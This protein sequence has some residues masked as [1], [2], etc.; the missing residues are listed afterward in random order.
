MN[1]DLYDILFSMKSPG[2]W[3]DTFERSWQEVDRAG[4]DS[5]FAGTDRIVLV[6]CGTS[7]YAGVYGKELFEV[8]SGIP[9][10][11]VDGN[12]GRY[13]D[14]KMYTKSTLY[15]GI[16][17][18][19]NSGTAVESLQAASKNGA[20]TLCITGDKD[21]RIAKASDVV[22]FFP[23][24]V[25]RVAT[26]TRSYVETLI[27][28]FALALKAGHIKKCKDAPE[29]SFVRAEIKKC[30]AAA[31]KIFDDYDEPMERLA[32]E[33]KSK[34]GFHVVG[35]GMNLATAHEAAL[36]L[37]EIGWINTEAME[38][39]S[40]MHGKFRG[41][42]S[43]SPFFV[44]AQ[45][46]RSL[47]TAVSFVAVARKVDAECVTVT[48]RMLAPIQDLSRNVIVIDPV[49]E[50]LKPMV[51]ILPVYIFSMYLG[52]AHGKENPAASQFG[53]PAQTFQFDELYPE[54]KNIL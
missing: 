3:E 49:W 46:D 31:A 51:F 17:N 48:D 39:E 42:G 1:L 41:A 10:S 35:C 8:F 13:T 29:L 7:N 2:F 50:L 44:L 20:K 16:S 33:Y 24:A 34:N 22:L 4:L 23:G 43:D 52:L 27:M 32:G 37:C 54:Y 19:G 40:F 11:A 28:L 25:D 14:K 9:A 47:R 26:K 53:R 15:I 18:T 30:G 6:G 21:S 38:L 45:D 12:S 36:K 5:L